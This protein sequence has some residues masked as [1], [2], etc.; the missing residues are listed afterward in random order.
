MR[1]DLDFNPCF[2]QGKTTEELW[3]RFMWAALSYGRKYTVE[4]GSH[5]GDY[6]LSLDCAMGYIA[7]PEARPLAPLATE[8]LIPPTS[9]EEIIKYFN[10]KVFS[11]DPP[12]PDEH[13]NYSE[14][15]YPLSMD[16]I[17]YYG[18]KG[19]GNAHAVLRVGDPFCFLDYSKPEVFVTDKSGQRHLDELARPTTPCLLGIDTRIVQNQMGDYFLCFYVMYRSW[20]LFGGFPENM[21]GFQMLKERMAMEISYL[22]GKLVLP[23]PSTVFCKDLHLYG[24]RVEAAKAWLKL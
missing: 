16:A 14:W 12:A 4:R 19:F 20:D 5:A 8:G 21:G 9:D 15:L 1:N 13:Y 10:T 3:K 23:G 18:I 6:R 24:S 17:E 2:Q 22:S 11:P 7:Y